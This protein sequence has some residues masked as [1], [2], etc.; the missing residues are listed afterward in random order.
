[1]ALPR[2]GPVSSISATSAALRWIRSEFMADF[3][4]FRSGDDTGVG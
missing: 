3:S 1:M 2:P 4:Q